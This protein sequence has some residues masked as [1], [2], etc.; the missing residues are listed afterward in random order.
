[1]SQHIG[2]MGSL[3]TLAAFE[4]SARQF[5]DLY[6]IDATQ[7]AADAHPGYQTRRWA[8]HARGSPSGWC[9]TTTPMSPPS[10]SSTGSRPAE[11]VIGFA[12][13]GTGYGVDGTISGGEVLVAGY[14]S[15]VP[16]RAPAP[17]PAARR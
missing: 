4:R 6:R 3:E 11:H 9:T 7:V 10:W 5:A 13:D 8:E 15:F 1:M 16:R 12:F 14:G 2:D 17:G